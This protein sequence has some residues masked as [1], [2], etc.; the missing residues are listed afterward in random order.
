VYGTRFF[1]GVRR[2]MPYYASMQDKIAPRDGEVDGSEAR[3]PR[4]LT[5]LPVQSSGPVTSRLLITTAS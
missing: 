4:P 3:F 1:F 2:T 5:S